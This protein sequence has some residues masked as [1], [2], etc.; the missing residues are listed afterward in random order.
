MHAGLGCNLALSNVPAFWLW[1][2]IRY[3]F[4]F[5]VFLNL[6]QS[7]LYMYFCTLTTHGWASCRSTTTMI[8]KVFIITLPWPDLRSMCLKADAPVRTPPKRSELQNVNNTLVFQSSC[9]ILERTDK[10]DTECEG[11]GEFVRQSIK[12]L[13]CLGSRDLSTAQQLLEI[14]IRWGSSNWGCKWVFLCEKGI[15]LRQKKL[16]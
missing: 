7:R 11:S 10:K 12:R 13:E 2:V 4:M 16:W 15:K 1:R 9:V 5:F 6:T 8:F 3:L 14:T